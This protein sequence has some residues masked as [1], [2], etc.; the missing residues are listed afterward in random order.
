MNEISMITRE[1][2]LTSTSNRIS[3]VFQDLESSLKDETAII[4]ADPIAD[5]SDPP[6]EDVQLEVVETVNQEDFLIIR[7]EFE[8]NLNEIAKLAEDI[9]PATEDYQELECPI[10]PIEIGEDLSVTVS[11]LEPVCCFPV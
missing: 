10:A 8:D 3:S 11:R 1:A 2:R 4:V 6:K 7:E 9:K 5:K